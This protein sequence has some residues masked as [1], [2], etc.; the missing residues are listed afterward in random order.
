VLVARVLDFPA[1]RGNSGVDPAS[2]VI[3]Y[4]RS[5]VGASL[6]DPDTGIVV[7]GLPAQAPAIPT[8]RLSATITAADF[9]EAKNLTTPRGA[10]LPNTT[11]R[12]V[13]LR[14]VA[15]PSATWVTP[16]TNAC[17]SPRRQELVVVASS[18]ARVRTVAF[19]ADGKRVATRRGT[20]TELY[21]AVWQTGRATSGKHRLTAVVRDVRGRTYRSDRLVRVCR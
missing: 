5:L 21:S 13:S 16:Q 7:F 12:E 19:H 20:A 11:F 2:L 4:Q 15:G 9:Q 3:A 1:R 14:G 6:Y 10:I 17:V 8:R 18:T